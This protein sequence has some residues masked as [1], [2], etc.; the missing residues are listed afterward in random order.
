MFNE[1]LL[2]EARMEFQEKNE[3][4]SFLAETLQK[5]LGY[6]NDGSFRPS[7][8]CESFHQ[9]LGNCHTPR[10]TLMRNQKHVAD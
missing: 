1:K 8:V 4:M 10:P 9:F 6:L 2:E 7:F 3:K 5:V